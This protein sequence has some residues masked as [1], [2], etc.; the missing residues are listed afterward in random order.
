MKKRKKR[1]KFRSL[2][3]ILFI[4]CAV[5]T[6]ATIVLRSNNNTN[7][8]AP[9]ETPEEQSGSKE[10]VEP[11]QTEISEE[12]ATIY[13]DEENN[14]ELPVRGATGYA[15]IDISILQEK[16]ISESETGILSAGQG[17]TILEE[18][19]AWWYVK[20]S[21]LEGWVMHE[22]CMIN[23]P[24]IIPSII[25]S[26]DNATASMMRSSGE[27]IPN[28]TDEILYECFSYSDR[29]DKEQYT[30]P[31]LY[32]MASKIAKAQLLAKQ[33]G[34]TLIIYETYRPYEVQRKIVDNFSMLVNS[35][36]KV[37]NGVNQS[38][39][40]I[41]WF[42]STRISNHQRG[43]AIDVSLGKIVAQEMVICGDFKY[44]EIL[45]YEEY[46]M[47][48]P[49]H[50]LSI[51]SATF[52]MPVSDASKTEWKSCKLAESMNEEACLLQRYCVDAGMIPLAS[53]WWHFNDL[54]SKE[55]A[56]NLGNRGEYYISDNYSIKPQRTTHQKDEGVI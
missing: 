27:P 2:F 19:D 1:E 34:N 5:C 26:N 30:M 7:P 4:F 52:D 21:E 48:T 16:G 10:T 38:P 23:L 17:F 25:Y 31:I 18:S 33:E 24:D 29:F 36:S 3:H 56:V 9:P 14:F 12:S 53:E 28:V 47:P 43:V 11:E 51:G 22:Y 20:T 35:N 41:G 50:E 6:I 46:I 54:D 40:S 44:Y 49:M 42:I 8:V 39:W 45:E 15:A 32:S 13:I 55:R 37:S